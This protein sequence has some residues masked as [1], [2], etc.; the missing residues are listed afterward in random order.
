M[1][2]LPIVYPEAILGD[3]IERRQALY[4]GCCGSA[5]LCIFRSRLLVYSA[6][7][8]VNRV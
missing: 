3:K 6:G 2:Q 8:G 5:L 7:S 1:S 4:S